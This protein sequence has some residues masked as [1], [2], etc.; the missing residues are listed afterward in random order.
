MTHSPEK[1]IQDNLRMIAIVGFASAIILV[2]G[3]GFIY[4]MT[5]FSATI[6][7]QEVE[8][9][10]ATAIAVYL[11]GVV[12]LL[13]LTLWAILSGKFRDIE[14]PKY[15]VLELHEQFESEARRGING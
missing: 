15:R 6:V 3:V 14:R 5:E 8:G 9:F 4:K 1:W 11:T 2:A 12:P 13:F 10:G 7:K